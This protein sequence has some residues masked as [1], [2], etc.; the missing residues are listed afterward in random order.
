MISENDT[1]IRQ[2]VIIANNS[3]IMQ[4]NYII[5]SININFYNIAEV[6]VPKRGYMIPK[7]YPNDIKI[8]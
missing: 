5:Y 7:K 3:M 4:G 2:E 1:V 6:Y 8:K